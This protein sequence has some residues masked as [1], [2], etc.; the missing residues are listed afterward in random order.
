MKTGFRTI[1]LSYHAY[2][3]QSRHSDEDVPAHLATHPVCRWDDA[4]LPTFCLVCRRD[5]PSRN[6]FSS[7]QIGLNVGR[8]GIMLADGTSHL[9]TARLQIGQIVARW[10]RRQTGRPTC[11]HFVPSSD[12]MA[13]LGTFC[14]VCRLDE[15]SADWAKCSQMGPSHLATAGLLIHDWTKCRKIGQNVDR[16]DA[17]SV[18]VLSA[19]LAKCSQMGPSHLVRARLQVGQN[20]GRLGK[21]L[22]DGTPHQLTS[23]LQIGQKVAR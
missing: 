4:H 2:R 15:I 21:M 22:T 11:Q 3:T 17:P 6:I 12:G 8:L 10:A 23:H 1:R 14:P 5:G 7:M 20:V 18:D 19:D 13:H 16:W 9:R